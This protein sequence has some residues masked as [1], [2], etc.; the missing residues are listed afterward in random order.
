MAIIPGNNL[1]P[2]VA[3]SM[4]EVATIP[5]VPSN[6]QS[7]GRET[8]SNSGHMYL[9]LDQEGLRFHHGIPLWSKD[10]EFTKVTSG[11]DR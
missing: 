6:L 5:V 2:L 3:L 4:S 11:S 1:I 8:V 9:V 10:E 7:G